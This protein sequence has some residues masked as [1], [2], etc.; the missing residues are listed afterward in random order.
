M[1]EHVWILSAKQHCQWHPCLVHTPW[2]TLPGQAV[3]LLEPKSQPSAPHFAHGYVL[4]TCLLIFKSTLKFSMP[5]RVLLSRGLC[6]AAD[7]T[8][9]PPRPCF[10][11]L[12][13]LLWL[14]T[15]VRILLLVFSVTA[16]APPRLPDGP[17]PRHSSLGEAL[18]LPLPAW[19]ASH[20]N[21]C[22]MV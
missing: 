14:W 20:T 17:L 18:S 7:R 22:K 13:L 19:A 15:C 1:C 5:L 9:P 16:T 12:L 11:W 4:F 2:G 10:L 3:P 21:V 8:G 6:A